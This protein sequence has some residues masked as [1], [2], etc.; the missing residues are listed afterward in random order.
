MTTSPATTHQSHDTPVLIHPTTADMVASASVAA[1]FLDSLG[2]TGHSI[3]V[4]P[5]GRVEVEV[6]R[7]DFLAAA[8]AATAEWG[9]ARTTEPGA[10][11]VDARIHGVPVQVWTAVEL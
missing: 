2:I 11:F 9:G 10:V 7:A 8:N 1:V 5:C 3:R 4:T 6:D